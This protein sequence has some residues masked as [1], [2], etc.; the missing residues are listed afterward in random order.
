M[1]GM[2]IS[3]NSSQAGEGDR[4][5]SVRLE[6]ATTTTTRLIDSD[7]KGGDGHRTTQRK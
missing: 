5:S 2:G 6:E 7:N 4:A 1:V 3:G